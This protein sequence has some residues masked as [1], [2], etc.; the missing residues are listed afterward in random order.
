M[1]A[2]QAHILTAVEVAERLHV[3]VSIVRQWLWSGR[4]SGYRRGGLDA[5]WRVH[6]SDLEQFIETTLGKTTLGMP[7]RR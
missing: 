6:A 1:T 5:G 2:A 7:S 4:L 3:S